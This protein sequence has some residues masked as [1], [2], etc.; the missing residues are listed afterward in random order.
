[1][2]TSCLD[3]VYCENAWNCSITLLDVDGNPIDPLLIRDHAFVVVVLG[4][5]PG[6]R[7]LGF[8]DEENNNITFRRRTDINENAYQINNVMCD[9]QYFAKYCPIDYKITLRSDSQ[10]CGNYQEIVGKHYGDVV[11]ITASQ[12]FRCRF[13]NWTR[14]VDGEN[15][16]VTEEPSFEH[17][18]TENVTFTAHYDSIL[19]RITA[20]P[21]YQNQGSCAG[22]GNYALN[23][24]VTI[25]ATPANENYTFGG[26]DDGNMETPRTVSV[27]GNK[28]Y[29]A[30]FVYKEINVMAPGVSGGNVVGTGAY[31]SGSVVTLQA[32]SEPG[33][34]FSH[35]TV[36]GETVYG[37][38]YRFVAESDTNVIPWFTSDTYSISLKAIPL[39]GG[40]FYP[41]SQPSY[42]YGEKATFKAIPLN[43]YRFVSW[44]DGVTVPERTFT[45][46]SNIRLSA[47]FEATPLMPTITVALPDSS[48][49]CALYY[50]G[51]DI[52]Y[53]QGSKI[54]AS[55]P[56]G[57]QIRLAPIIPE[58]QTLVSVT[59]SDDEPIWTE[60]GDNGKQTIIY[61]VGYSNETLVLNYEDNQYKLYLSIEPQNG[62]I[63][64]DG[65]IFNVTIDGYTSS[66]TLTQGQPIRSYTGL[67]HG[68]RVVLNAPQTVGTSYNFAYWVTD[69]QTVN[70][71][72]M[73]FDVKSNMRCRAVYVQIV[74]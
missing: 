4:D 66:T 1:M 35:W 45:F 52:G 61:T 49:T 56:E 41:S 42:L 62:D 29:V 20:K 36:D 22:S 69:T 7:F 14:I 5:K 70:T 57:S 71:Y 24:A 63:L 39:I 9:K 6:Y 73:T 46:S 47:I 17:V 23:S 27:T 55:V 54:T 67:A 16:I 34:R 8:V 3:K 10:T 21:E 30:R 19:Y 11:T 65:A 40:Y 15:V 60:N 50:N 53:K 68:T 28:T 26:W 13:L 64:A 38:T 12:G 37:E 32:V 58:G 59:D 43:G 51:E 33:W 25:S 48:Y 31:R 18:V 2:A 72:Y 74:K 44:S